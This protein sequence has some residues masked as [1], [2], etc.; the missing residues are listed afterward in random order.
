MS[1]F[2]ESGDL[3]VEEDDRGLDVDVDGGDL[4]A[5]MAGGD[6]PTASKRGTKP[7]TKRGRYNRVSTQARKRI[8]ESYKAGGDWKLTA[9]ANG[10]AVQ[11]AYKYI[12]CPDKEE[13]APRGG[14][15]YQKVT[16][17]H[18]EKL[19]QYIEC[20]PQITLTDMVNKLHQDTGLRVTSSTI[21][22]HLHGQFYTV[23]QA[24]PQPVTMNNPENKARRAAYTRRL[25]ELIGGGKTVI[26]ID[27][28]NCNL[29]LRRKEGRSRR[30]TR[31]SVKSA[32]AQGPNVHIIGA[33]TQ[34]GLVHWQRKRGSYRKDDCVDWLRE[35]L[36]HCPE[37][38]RDLVVVCDNAPVHTALEEAFEEE[39]VFAG[40]ELLRLAPYSSPMN[41]IEIIWS[42]VKASLKRE[43]AASLDQA[44]NTQPGLTQGEHRLRHLESKIDIAM[45][46]VTQ[47]MCLRACN[48]VQT[49]FA[50]CLEQRD[51]PIGV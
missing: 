16:S 9:T 51:L 31:C 21:H 39:G 2:N 40:A 23:K 35:V 26:Y 38:P 10:V 49:Y 7:G 8:I 41:P 13:P 45:T 27:E 14:R 24:R 11:T 20:N 48:H 22:K 43:L 32:A 33:M 6:G 17:A 4:E 34:T 44:L 18:I 5:G 3:M 46:A 15:R 1:S 19:I 42:A 25:M 12:R 30:G 50:G 29:F 28:T 37:D 47:R 36:M